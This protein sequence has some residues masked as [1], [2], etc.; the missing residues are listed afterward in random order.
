MILIPKS[1]KIFGV[2]KCW[3]VLTIDNLAS[4][5]MIAPIWPNHRHRLKHSLLSKFKI[6]A[7]NICDGDDFHIIQTM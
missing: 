3:H 6:I 5:R 1:F 4:N 2:E 7:T